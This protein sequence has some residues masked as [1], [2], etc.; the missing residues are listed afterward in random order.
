MFSEKKIALVAFLLSIFLLF[1][2]IAKMEVVSPG[3]GVIEGELKNIDI[4]ASDSGFINALN[5]KQG[6]HVKEGD[7]LL[8]YINLDLYYQKLTNDNFIQDLITEKKNFESEKNQLLN[9]FHENLERNYLKEIEINNTIEMFGSKQS[10][11]LRFVKRYN[12]IVRQSS[13]LSRKREIN[14][15]KIKRLNERLKLA[16]DKVLL[17]NKSSAPKI[18]VIDSMSE[19]ESIRLSIATLDTEEVDSTSEYQSKKDAFEF[20]LIKRL[21]EIDVELK[22]IT[23]KLIEKES[24]RRTIEGKEKANVITAPFDG[25][26]LESDNFFALNGYINKMQKVVTI[27]RS[28]TESIIK[29]KVDTKYRPYIYKGAPVNIKVRSS[30]V[31]KDYKGVLTN[32]SVDSFI[33]NE[34]ESFSNRYYSVEVSISKSDSDELEVLVGVDVDLFIVSREVSIGSFIIQMF[35]GNV[36]LTE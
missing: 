26:L 7:L 24:I 19:V 9:L 33:P 30:A 27:K 16:E 34:K 5:I 3:T 8:S 14:I 22:N 4:V 12:S 21:E 18:S 2:G 23:T 35:G 29:G 31:V 13:E 32:I 11:V 36:Y 17:L 1:I 6:S 25:Y 20:D 10:S 28:K 15:E